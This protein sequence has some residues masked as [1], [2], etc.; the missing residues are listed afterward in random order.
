[1]KFA[2]ESNFPFF[3]HCET[4]GA[5]RRVDSMIIVRLPPQ[6]QI[7]LLVAGGGDFYTH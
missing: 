4:V 6:G 1:M 3:R 7:C 2:V 5:K